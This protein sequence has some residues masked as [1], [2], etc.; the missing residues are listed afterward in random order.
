MGRFT[1]DPTAPLEERAKA[2][3]A[4]WHGSINQVRTYSGL[5]YITHPAA[6]VEILRSVTNDAAVLAAG[7]LHD[8]VEDTP[9]TIEQIE[10]EFGREVAELVEQ[11]TNVATRADGNRTMRVAINRAHSASA[12]PRAKTVKLADVIHNVS[13]ILEC[14]YDFAVRYV[15]EKREL[16]EVLRGGDP[17]LLQRA[18]EVIDWATQVLKVRPA[19]A[20]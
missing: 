5:P 19:L 14:P 6:V 11:L 12:S 18:R 4:Y 2:F 8:V 16:I 1:T 15:E 10:K 13:C 17:R 7:W 9:C 3:S 20:S